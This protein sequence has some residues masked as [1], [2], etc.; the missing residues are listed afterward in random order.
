MKLGIDKYTTQFKNWVNSQIDKKH[1]E[2]I[3]SAPE[4][5]DTIAE[6]AQA[7]KDNETVVEALDAA[8]GNK[9]DKLISGTNIKQINGQDILGKGNIEISG[10]GSS[11][12]P[13]WDASEGEE[14]FIKNKP[15][16]IF[17]S[18]IEK[19]DDDTLRVH[20]AE[21]EYTEE[22]AS[23]AQYVY[24][25]STVYP[26]N[27]EDITIGSGRYMLTITYDDDYYS[28]SHNR[29]DAESLL[30][31]YEDGLWSVFY[32]VN[33][34]DAIYL[35]N[36]VVKTLPQKLSNDAKSQVLEN[37]GLG[38]VATK[39]GVIRQTQTW[40]LAAD[41]GYDYVMSDLVRGAIPQANIDLF[42]SAG[43]VFNEESGY[44]ELNGLTDIS[45]EEMSAIYNA[46]F[47]MVEGYWG[48][49]I[50]TNIFRPCN[51]YNADTA[52]L[53]GFIGMYAN[54]FCKAESFKFT[55]QETYGVA[56]KNTMYGTYEG[57]IYLKTFGKGV[58]VCQDSNISDQAFKECYSLET[59]YVRGLKKNIAFKD[60]AR[61]S[62]ASILYMVANS[63]ATSATTI[64]LHADAYTRAMADTEIQAALASHPN[65]SLAS[66]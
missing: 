15:Y 7:I 51:V 34:I 4:T 22:F 2:F 13:D 25:D 21:D 53:Y 41:K 31:D 36:N 61:L 64:T 60:S 10:G 28:I 56:L 19:G 35:T 38:E 29:I 62:N 50:R 57:C 40:T 27:K 46:G 42:T 54:R 48:N 39:Q 5:L 32:V 8:I 65:V 37:L 33:G 18:R 52:Q 20:I 30:L 24:W 3:G 63:A 45:H 1:A 6:V 16:E 9:Q 44:F 11:A 14:G 23:I 17:K 26:L 55:E 58:F 66:A 43:A 49:N 12:T 47:K 59:I